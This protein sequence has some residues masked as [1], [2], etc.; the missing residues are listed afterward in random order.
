[1]AWPARRRRRRAARALPPRRGRK[2]M[3]GRR[4][5]GQGLL[6]TAAL[7]AAP[8]IARAQSGPVRLVVPF[9]PGGTSHILARLLAEPLGRELGQ[10][11]IVENRG[12]AGGNIGADLVAK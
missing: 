11:I 8:A 12:G 2:S 4:L 10:S 5:L 9:A 6:A 7:L 3:T 1:M